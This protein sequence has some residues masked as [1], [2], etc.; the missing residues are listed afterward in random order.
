MDEIEY[1]INMRKDYVYKLYT[2][3]THYKKNITPLSP[4]TLHSIEQVIREDNKH[5]K[6]WQLRLEKLKH[7]NIEIQSIQSID[8]K[9]LT[10]QKLNEIAYLK[11]SFTQQSYDNKQHYLI[12][13][14]KLKQIRQSALNEISYK[15]LDTSSKQKQLYD[16]QLEIYKSQATLKE[17]C[18]NWK[19][20]QITQ[21][22]NI[23]DAIYAIELLCQHIS[24]D[25]DNFA[26]P[27]QT[28]SLDKIKSLFF[29]EQC[30]KLSALIEAFLKDFN[31]FELLKK[32]KADKH[33]NI[34]LSFTQSFE[35][36]ALGS[37]RQNITM[38]TDIHSTQKK[39]QFVYSNFKALQE[40]F[41]PALKSLQDKKHKLTNLYTD[42]LDLTR[43]TTEKWVVANYPEIFNNLDQIIKERYIELKA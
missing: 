24:Q 41:Q 4:S 7:L 22:R 16:L 34:K 21:L 23:T 19:L 37:I 6:E 20:E 13:F 12:V 3:Y 10:F 17:Y 25:L 32:F 40:I 31:I 38:I 11:K 35:N 36:R 27:L 43:I 5:W 8:D 18:D 2:F 9:A 33:H 30:G 28:N 14:T 15:L 42:N 26:N 29:A 39:V 1:I